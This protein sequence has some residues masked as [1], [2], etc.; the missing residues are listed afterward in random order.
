MGRAE[1]YAKKVSGDVQKL[2]ADRYRSTQ[3]SAFTQAVSGQ[4]AIERLVKT[5]ITRNNVMVALNHFYMNFGKKIGKLRKTYTGPTLQLEVCIEFEKWLSRGLDSTTLDDIV[6]AMGFENC[7]AAP[8]ACAWSW[9]RKLTFSGNVSATNLDDFPVLV[10]L[11][12]ANFDF[13]KAH[14]QGHDIR[15]M[16]SDTCPTDGTPLKHEIELWDKPGANAWI[17]VKVPRIDGGSIN[18][19]IY[20]FYG[21]AGVP[22]GQDV[23]NV[24]TAGYE[25]VWHLRT[26]NDSTINANHV[27]KKGPGEPADA[28]TGIDGVQDFDGADDYLEGNPVSAL[29]DNIS[30]GAVMFRLQPPS[31]PA[32]NKLIWD[33][34]GVTEANTREVILW[35]NTDNMWMHHH[36]G[37]VNGGWTITSTIVVVPGAWN[38]VTFTWGAAGGKCYIDGAPAGADPSVIGTSGGHT[39]MKHGRQYA[40]LEG[41]G[42]RYDGYM[43]EFRVCTTQRTPDWVMAQFKTQDETLITYGA[44]QPA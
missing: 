12:N 16:D 41:P 14:V 27:A 30:N 19:F 39:Q 15:F 3:V 17:W 32:N 35:R 18:D 21:N 37:P 2:I 44:E 6:V 22:D 36:N 23:P 26:V 10:H 13:N 8:P 42:D 20:M 34:S 4:V 11:T 31:T 9:K 25:A 33:A 1:K 5:I 40:L 43:D 29:V 24:W 7:F 28:A 38:H